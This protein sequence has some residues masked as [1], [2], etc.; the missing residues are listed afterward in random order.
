ML[1]L[2]E[3]TGDN[4]EI[5]RTSSFQNILDQIQ[6]SSTSTET[7]VLVELGKKDP[8]AVIVLFEIVLESTNAD[9]QW[10]AMLELSELVKF[11]P[12]Y[13]APF[14]SKAVKSEHIHVQWCAILATV[15]L[16]RTHPELAAPILQ[17]ILEEDISISAPG[18]SPLVNIDPHNP[19]IS[20]ALLKSAINSQDPE[21]EWTA[22]LEIIHFA[23][24]YPEKVI[25]ILEQ[26][27]ENENPHIQ[28][29]A[30]LELIELSK[31]NPE[32]QTTS[33]LETPLINLSKRVLVEYGKE[34]LEHVLPLLEKAI[35]SNEYSLQCTAILELASLGKIVPEHIIQTIEKIFDP[36]VKKLNDSL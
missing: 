29:L 6:S 1:S 7:R 4:L 31:N 26:A 23:H 19:D 21:L 35:R 8:Q 27:I 32:L 9:I 25:P 33:N 36:S 10:S 12:P 2:D 30:S 18:P 16:A 24:D 3:E 34:N 15:D 5:Q 17:E 20:F 13:F 14:L 11:H 22:M 28:W